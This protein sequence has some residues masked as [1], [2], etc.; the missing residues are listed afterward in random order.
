V[1]P[2][3]SV[4]TFMVAFY[5]PVS[6]KILLSTY[7]TISSI[8]RPIWHTSTGKSNKNDYVYGILLTF[9]HITVIMTSI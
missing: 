7:M 1:A 8:H 9:A 2:Q 5:K 4:T 3:G 6:G